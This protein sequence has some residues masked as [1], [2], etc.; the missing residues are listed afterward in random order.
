[1]RNGD[2]VSNFINGACEGKGSNL[3]IEGNRLIN[4][5]TCIAYRLGN[6]IYL[7]STKYSQTTSRHQNQ[8]RREGYKVIE[9]KEKELKEFVYKTLDEVI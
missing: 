7:N 3:K 4:Y 2:L 8:I 9:M 6:T 1:M 5:T